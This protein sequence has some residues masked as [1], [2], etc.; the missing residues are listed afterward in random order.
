MRGNK[1]SRGISGKKKNSCWGQNLED[2]EFL[3]RNLAFILHDVETVKSFQY[4]TTN[5]DYF[6]HNCVMVYSGLVLD[7]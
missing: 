6:I 1:H 5:L 4:T 2:L 7:N 3:P